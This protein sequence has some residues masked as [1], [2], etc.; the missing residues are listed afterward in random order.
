MSEAKTAHK[1]ARDHV[2][3][4]EARCRAIESLEFPRTFR[5]LLDNA[6][7]RFGT[8]TAIRMIEADRALGFAALRDQVRS[9]ADALYR[10]G[11]RKGTRVAV[12]LPN[13]LEFPFSWLALAQLGAVMVPT[14][15]A[16]TGRELD[17]LYNDA[18]VE[19]LIAHASLLG[20]FHS[21]TARPAALVDEHVFVVGAGDAGPYRS[22][23]ALLAG[24]DPGFEPSEP[25][26]GRDLLNIQYTSGTT[27]FPK[28][29]MQHQRY[30][31]VLG[32]SIAE[33]QPDIGSL[34]SDHP[35]FYMD[36][37]WQLIW[38]LYSG[39]TVNI[40]PRMSV[41]RFWSWVRDYGIEWAWFPMPLLNTPASEGE[42]L[43][44]IKIF[45]AGA[46]SKAAILEAEKRFGVPVR[47]AYG[48]TEIGGGSLVPE[49]LPDD[50]LLHTVG[51]RA[52]FRELRIVDEQGRE[53]P[54]GTPGELVVRGDGVFLGYYNRPEA[55]R[56]SFY[57]DWFRTGDLF[58]RDELGYYRIIGRFKDMI[59]RSSENIS[60]MEIEH[61]A[62]QMTEIAEAAAVPV[63]DDYRGEEVKLYV[64]LNEGF[65]PEQCP[66]GKIAEHCALSLAPFKLPR[67]F[68]YVGQFPCTPSGKVAK[69]ELVRGVEDLRE[70]SYDR[71]EDV[72][73]PSRI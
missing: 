14:N 67:Y 30:W 13:S 54:H 64:Q 23:E 46:I 1:G 60:A 39:A 69:H 70:D 18:G 35:W 6:A 42:D 15:T 57:G 19:F 10:S 37:Q 68:A 12:L 5:Q 45:H 3:E 17:Y 8:R 65:S 61:V 43:H 27:G 63:P 40:A 9:L 26:D 16:Y 56:E 32:C 72:W 2:T 25:L 36:P 44:T 66:P 73:R 47:G 33:L 11:V 7:D 71:V 34:L 21:M 62:R 55:N 31:I 59:R 53:V 50:D 41:S 52:P 58:V 49:E 22:F 38:S 28:G 20:A 29:C 48:M 4:W 24:G 51:L